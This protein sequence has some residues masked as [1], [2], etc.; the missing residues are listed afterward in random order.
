MFNAVWINY[1][2]F[3]VINKA[4]KTLTVLVLPIFC[5]IYKQLLTN[6]FSAKSLSCL[7]CFDY[8][9]LFFEKEVHSRRAAGITRCPFFRSNIFK[10]KLQ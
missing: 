1:A 3:W 9:L 6:F 5:N 4:N 7:L 2:S 8:D 10:M